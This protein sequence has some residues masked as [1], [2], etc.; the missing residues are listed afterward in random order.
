MVNPGK[1]FE[2]PTEMR[3]F[4]ERS[5]EQARK[6]F[7]GFVGAAHKAASAAEDAASNAQTNAKDMTTKVFDYA[8]ANVAAAF[9]H[10]QKLVRAKDPQEAL[11]LQAEYVRQQLE[12]IQTQAKEMGALVQKTAADATQK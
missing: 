5:V 8:G 7:E 9:D 4:A 12:A 6:A 3:D 2:I 1:A 11:K 10:A